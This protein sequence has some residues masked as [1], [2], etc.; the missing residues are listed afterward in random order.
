MTFADILSCLLDSTILLL[1][2]YILAHIIIAY[3]MMKN[4]ESV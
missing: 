1:Y 4:P 2:I 3:D